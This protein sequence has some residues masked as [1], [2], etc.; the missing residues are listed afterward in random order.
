M[1]TCLNPPRKTHGITGLEEIGIVGTA[2][3]ERVAVAITEEDG[4]TETGAET[5]MNAVVPVMIPACKVI[6]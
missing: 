6:G 2:E 4:K 1:W 5:E 3:V